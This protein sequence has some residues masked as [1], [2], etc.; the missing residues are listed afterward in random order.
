MTQSEVE[1]ILTAID[2]VKTDIKE[3]FSR[4]DNFNQRLAG[5]EGEHKARIARG[6]DCSQQ[7][8]IVAPPMSKLLMA[9]LTG[10]S[11]LQVGIVIILAL[12]LHKLGW[13]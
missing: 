11:I 6:A 7:Q 12:V 3:L 10:N 1:T 4:L 9:V 8:T 5:L 2:G 13:L